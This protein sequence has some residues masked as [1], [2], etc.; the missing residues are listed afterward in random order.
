MSKLYTEYAEVYHLMYQ[1][2]IDYDEEF[3]DYQK[4]L[5]DFNCKSLLEVAC[6][7]GQLGRRLVEA[8]Y[9]YQGLDMSADMLDFA[10]EMLPGGQFH[11]Q[12]MRYIQV[13]DTFDAVLITAR[14]VSY[15]LQNSDALSTFQNIKKVLKPGGILT[16]DFIDA[17]TYIP[18]IL[19]NP[20]AIHE[21]E[22]AKGKFKREN[23]Y[24][25]N[26]TDGWCLTWDA[27]YF[28]QKEEGGYESLGNDKHQLRAFTEDEMCLLLELS[29]LKVQAVLQRPSYAYNTKV[30][31]AQNV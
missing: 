6:G 20:M 10:R 17:N 9:T 8:G 2:L 16:F 13:P 31:I 23:H 7:T 22:T 1:G 21:V 4:I 11:Q 25:I 27:K 19:A 28:K 14:S 3:V 26:F 30:A 12:D 5:A 29:G 15:L 24:Y 18:H